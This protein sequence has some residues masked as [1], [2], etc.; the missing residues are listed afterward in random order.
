[1]SAINRPS[2]GTLDPPLSRDIV[3]VNPQG[4]HLRPATAFA[5]LARQFASS[6]A[7]CRDG[8]RAN[9]KSQMELLMLAAESGAR[10]T[11]EVE[12]PDAAT[13]LDPLADLLAA[14]DASDD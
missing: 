3:V 2:A 5:K 9:G 6:V 1:M 11:L 10:L 12:G 4:L 8:Q 7:V 14:A 13:A